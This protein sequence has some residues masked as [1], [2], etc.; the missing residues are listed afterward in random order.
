MEI[1][2]LGL[3]VAF[4]IDFEIIFLSRLVGRVGRGE[5]AVINGVGGD[6][7]NGVP[8]VVGLDHQTGFPNLH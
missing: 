8:A 5:I 3:H 6:S 7:G 4:E 2:Q 1:D